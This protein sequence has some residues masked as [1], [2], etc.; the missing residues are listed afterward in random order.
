[1]SDTLTGKGFFLNFKGVNIDKEQKV[2]KNENCIACRL[3]IIFQFTI[4]F[5][6]YSVN[7]YHLLGTILDG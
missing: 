3:L 5:K 2:G 6:K 4:S 7:A 1:M